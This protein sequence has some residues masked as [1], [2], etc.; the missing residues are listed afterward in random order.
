MGIL[1]V[2]LQ[3]LSWPGVKALLPSQAVACLSGDGGR[4]LAT[5][6]QQHNSSAKCPRLQTVEVPNEAIPTP[7][8]GDAPTLQCLQIGTSKLTKQHWL[9]VGKNQVQNLW[10]LGR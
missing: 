3:H 7:L 2:G 10:A 9:T 4:A 1:V 5:S 8:E 6:K